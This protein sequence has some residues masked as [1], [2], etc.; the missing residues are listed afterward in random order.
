MKVYIDITI[1]FIFR[2]EFF[3]YV[4][5]RIKGEDYF[6]MCRREIFLGW[7]GG[8]WFF[9]WLFRFSVLEGLFRVV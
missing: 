1:F 3:I 7:V 8:R 2:K 5:L 9:V 4:I 6:I